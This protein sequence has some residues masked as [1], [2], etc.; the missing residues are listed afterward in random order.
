[1]QMKDCTDILS[2]TDVAAEKF[3]DIDPDWECSSAVK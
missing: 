1:M 3:F 2:T